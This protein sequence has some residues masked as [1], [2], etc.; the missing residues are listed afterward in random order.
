M[1]S[2][3]RKEDFF[4]CFS[5]LLNPDRHFFVFYAKV[6]SHFMEES[7]SDLRADTLKVAVT[8]VF[9]GTLV[10]GDTLR[11]ERVVAPIRGERNALIQS[12]QK[13]PI[14]GTYSFKGRLQ[15]P[16][17][18]TSQFNTIL[19]IFIMSVVSINRWSIVLQQNCTSSNT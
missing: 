8:I 1:R 14:T 3:T 13:T 9:N 11:Q 12:Q 7:L 5:P 15:N 4:C 16:S 10:D 19:A 2:R 18:G 6:M 17:R